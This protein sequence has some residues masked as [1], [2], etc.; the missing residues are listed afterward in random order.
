MSGSG[1]SDIM[2]GLQT[3][4]GIGAT[5]LGYPEIGIP[6]ATGGIGGLTGSGQQGATGLGGLL[7]SAQGTGT[8]GAQSPL[9]MANAIAPAAQS[10]MNAMGMNP[11]QRPQTAT[12]PTQTPQAPPMG[13]RAQVNLAPQQQQPVQAAGAMNN[14]TAGAGTMAGASPQNQ[15]LQQ[16]LQ[17]LGRPPGLA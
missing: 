6:L 12:P 13:N 4:A 17:M 14:V 16:I 8:T 7:G 10:I 9:Q 3:A 5:V 11:Q 15:Y 2:G 1:L